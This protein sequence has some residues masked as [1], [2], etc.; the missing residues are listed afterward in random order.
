MGRHFQDLFHERQFLPG[1]AYP[2]GWLG[3]LQCRQQLAQL[4][5]AVGTRHSQ[6]GRN[7]L[8]GTKEIREHRYPALARIREQQC[9]ASA[10]Q[11]SVA[12]LRHFEIRAYRDV[13][14]SQLAT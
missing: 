5:K 12:D 6:S 11:C 10:A 2:A 13:D 7:P 4:L 3:R 14:S 9:G 1:F 8:R